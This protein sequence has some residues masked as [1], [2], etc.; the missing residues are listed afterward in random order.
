MSNTPLLDTFLEFASTAKLPFFTPKADYPVLALNY[1]PKNPFITK[2]DFLLLGFNE[3]SFYHQD[4][5][6]LNATYFI[7]KTLPNESIENQPIAMTIENNFTPIGV[8]ARNLHE[9][10]S[11]LVFPQSMR[12]G[13]IY[14]Y[15]YHWK[16]EVGQEATTPT[17][18][19]ESEIT[20][21]QG[22]DIRNGQ[23]ATNNFLAF[24]EKS[25]I[26]ICED[27]YKTVFEALNHF[28]WL[29]S[30]ADTY[31]LSKNFP[32]MY[33]PDLIKDFYV[34]ISR[35]R[36]SLPN[37][38]DDA[39]NHISQSGMIPH[40]IRADLVHY[41]VKIGL[42][43]SHG[44]YAIWRIF[45]NKKLEEN[46]IV[47]LDSEASPVAVVACNFEEFIA[48]IHIPFSSIIYDIEYHTEY[49]YE[50]EEFDDTKLQKYLDEFK[51]EN[52]ADETYELP[53]R[54][55]LW[56][57]FVEKNTFHVQDK[58][59]YRIIKNAYLTMPKLLDW[60][61]KEMPEQWHY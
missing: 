56:F 2:E 48:I 60:L 31:Q 30:N 32:D 4:Y 41:F 12:W 8:V 55:S 7:W 21:F 47:Y 38:E 27:V 16:V 9:F 6:S 18:Q 19:S 20:E 23:N 36:I 10:L 35:N 39:G 44:Y 61:K 25:Q 53:E 26:P 46:P 49:G 40:F 11:M 54:A 45:P 22:D 24:L 29:D 58:H 1:L 52:K 37:F 28:E 13:L 59:P 17:G 34:F 42:T 50:L 3:R 57:D 5:K 14:A 43:S 33:I 15:E 51:E